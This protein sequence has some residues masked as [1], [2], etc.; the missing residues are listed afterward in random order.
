MTRVLV[1]TICMA[2]L[3]QATWAAP[4]IY[5]PKPGSKERKAILDALRVPATKM[6]GKP[7]TFTEVDL[8]VSQG[9]AYVDAATIDSKGKPIGAQVTNGVHALLRKSNNKW[10]VLDW[11][12]V[13][14]VISI[15]WE[16]QYPKVPKRLWPHRR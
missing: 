4:K 12:Y 1:L 9:W 11:G 14:D 3:T 16:K 15:D 2:L 5:T 8:K 13:T 7:V 6:N 10:R